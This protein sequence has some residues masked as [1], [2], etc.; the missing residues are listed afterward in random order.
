MT[1]EYRLESLMQLR[2]R[3]VEDAQRILQSKQRSLEELHRRL[4]A[5]I[6]EE[7]RPSRPAEVQGRDQYIAH[8]KKAIED[9]KQ[10]LEQVQHGL[11]E[12]QKELW[13]LQMHKE[14]WIAEQG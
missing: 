6:A 5:L 11:D 2:G 7:G 13:V 8:C 3:R 4:N 12:E 14:K 10:E 1:E 9:L